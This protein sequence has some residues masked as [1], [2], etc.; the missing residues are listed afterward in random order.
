M[1]SLDGLDDHGSARDHHLLRWA[2][3]VVSVHELTGERRALTDLAPCI[4]SVFDKH[5][6]LVRLDARIE[7]LGYIDLLPHREDDG[8][9]YIFAFV[10]VVG[11]LP[12]V[13]RQ[14]VEV[15]TAFDMEHEETVYRKH[16]AIRLNCGH[17]AARAAR[18]PR[19]LC[20]STQR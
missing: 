16:N 5:P 11:L 17:D 15:A 6:T 12:S 7:G 2:V 13:R 14:V 8:R 4:A 20:E 10:D 1:L 9:T 19:C 18:V 3:R